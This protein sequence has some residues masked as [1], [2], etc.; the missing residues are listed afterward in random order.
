MGING[1]LAL[2]TSISSGS[3]VQPPSGA[4]YAPQYVNFD[5]FAGGVTLNDTGCVFGPVTAPWGTLT[6]F[7]VVDTLGNPIQ[8]PGTLQSPFTPMIGQLVT[9]PQGS[10][11]LV[12]GSQFTAGPISSIATILNQSGPTTSGTVALSSGQY[13][14]VMA[15]GARSSLNLSN[16]NQINLVKIILGGTVAP[17]SGDLG[18]S[19]I[20]PYS[21]WPPPSVSDLIPSDSIWAIGTAVSGQV[22]NFQYALQ[23]T[24]PT[25]P[26]A[27]PV[28]VVGA[29]TSGS[30][31]LSSGAYSLVLASGSRSVILLTNASQ[32]NTV[33]VILGGTV[34][35]SS[36]AVGYSLIL[37]FSNWPPPGMGDFVPSD[38]IWTIGTSDDQILNYLTG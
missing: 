1:F 33:R 23:A 37:P 9:V 2:G 5:T 28:P 31:T 20:L 36:G 30:I 19:L 24:P 6:V 18:Y 22:L 7:G 35:P 3:V 11:T 15:S 27:P 32:A 10:I 12:V 13:T 38:A 8:A 14:L 26:P 34:A 16:V 4:G 25:P 29:T 21:T 17:A